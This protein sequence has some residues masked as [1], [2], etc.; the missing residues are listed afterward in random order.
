MRVWV[1]LPDLASG[2]LP[3]IC[4]KTGVHCRT[5]CRVRLS[6]LPVWIARFVP[7]SWHIDATVGHFTRR[8]V[9]GVL[10][11][12]PSA[13]RRIFWVLAVGQH[14]CRAAGYLFVMAFVVALALPQMSLAPRVIAAGIGA[15]VIATVLNLLG[16]TW[17]IG[18]RLGKNK[19][20]VRLTG[21]HP[22][23][24][25][26]VRAR[27]RAQRAAAG[28]VAQRSTP[29]SNALAELVPAPTAVGAHT[30]KP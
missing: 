4:V 10:P 28:A 16:C 30:S 15:F 25:A 17:S 3:P 6:G 8:A 24:A 5:S 7:H 18:G 19:R 21:V 1:S 27:Y 2:D 20:W 14:S 29:R 12:T 23:F 11:M 9:L 13:H 26:A 22:R